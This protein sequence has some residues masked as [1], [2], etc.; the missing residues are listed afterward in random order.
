MMQ[1]NKYLFLQTEWIM[2]NVLVIHSLVVMSQI[3]MWVTAIRVKNQTRECFCSS[4]VS[5]T[6]WIYLTQSVSFSFS[7]LYSFRESLCFGIYTWEMPSTTTDLC[8]WPLG[9]ELEQFGSIHAFTNQACNVL[10]CLTWTTY[11]LWKRQMQPYKDRIAAPTFKHAVKQRK[12]IDSEEV[13]EVACS[14]YGF[15]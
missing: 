7:N 10:I 12:H 13:E 9:A 15:D 6:V 8:C 1:S 5:H 3:K 14:I 11:C 2:N 4:R